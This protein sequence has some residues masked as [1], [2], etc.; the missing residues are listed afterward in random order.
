MNI[1]RISKSKYQTQIE[2]KLFN[3]IFK[4]ITHKNKEVAWT[5]GIRNYTNQGKVVLFLDYD[6]IL[7]E[8]MLIPEL[9]YLQ[10]KYKLSDLYI[11]KSSHKEHS[12]H[13]IGLDKLN[14]RT[15]ADILDE[16]SC[17]Q[18]YKRTPLILDHSSWVLRITEKGDT[19]SP[20]YL[21]TLK[22]KYQDRE[23]SK[24]HYLFLK[25]H[26]NIEMEEPPNLD[27]NT[28]LGVIKYPTL[29]NIKQDMNKTKI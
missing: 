2:L 16:S 13:V 6:E 24:A 8:E 7:L 19:Q 12:Y 28:I 3:R 21:M 15:W 23:K 17:D 27:D 9:K 25:Y 10:E 22:S 20:K 5:A 11:I 4:F 29:S 1:F 14:A 18:S 26:Y